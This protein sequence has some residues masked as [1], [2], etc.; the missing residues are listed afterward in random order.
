MIKTAALVALLGLSGCSWIGVRS[1]P[2]ASRIGD[3]PVKCNGYA[4][5]VLDTVGAVITLGVGTVTTVIE[6]SATADGVAVVRYGHRAP[7]QVGYLDNAGDGVRS[8]L[9]PRA[10]GRGADHLSGAVEPLL[11]PGPPPDRGVRGGLGASK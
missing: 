3:G 10:V 9:W 5:P 7:H 4:L 6:G 2:T 11:H 8:R 1:H